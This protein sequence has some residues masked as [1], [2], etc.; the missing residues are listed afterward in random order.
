MA[1]G[2]SR[3]RHDH[4]RGRAAAYRGIM[5]AILLALARVQAKPRRCFFTAFGNRLLESGVSQPTAS[6]PVMIFTYRRF[7]RTTI[8]TGGVGGRPGPVGTYF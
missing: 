8:G 1:L 4:V 5:T 3:W 2:A 6:L 7:H